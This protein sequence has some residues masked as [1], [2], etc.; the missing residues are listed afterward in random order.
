MPPDWSAQ[1]AQG[2]DTLRRHAFA[3]VAHGYAQMCAHGRQPLVDDRVGQLAAIVFD[4]LIRSGVF[5]EARTVDAL[6]FV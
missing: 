6:R 3:E 5:D 2:V 1:R 4:Q